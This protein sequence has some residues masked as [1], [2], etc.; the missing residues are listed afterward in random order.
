MGLLGSECSQTR[1]FFSGLVDFYSSWCKWADKGTVGT[2]LWPSC[3]LSHCGQSSTLSLSH[4]LWGFFSSTRD[5]LVQSRI[6]TVSQSLLRALNRVGPKTLGG[7]RKHHTL[8]NN[9]I[10]E[11]SWEAAVGMTDKHSHFQHCYMF[12]SS[13]VELLSPSRGLF[14]LFF[15]SPLDQFSLSLTRPLLPL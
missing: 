14:L 9:V 13:A 1:C 2:G 6:F 10:T 5:R 4:W 3:L 8:L 15:S 7:H 12:L 11:N